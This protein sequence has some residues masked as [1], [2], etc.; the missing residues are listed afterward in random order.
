[1]V[2]RIRALDWAKT[3]LGP[4]DGWPHSLKAIVDTLLPLGLPMV[5]MWG[6]ELVQVYNDAACKLMGAK[7][8]AGLGQPTCECWPEAWPISAPIYD[9]VLAG[10]TVLLEDALYR[11][12]RREPV[13]DAWFTLSFSPVHDDDGVIA[14]V[15]LTGVE[16]TEQRRKEDALR[17]AESR[18]RALFE[19]IDEGYALCE[20]SFGDHGEACDVR[21]LEVNAGF[22]RVSG[23][24]NA[25]GRTARELSPN[26]EPRWLAVTGRVVKTGEPVRFEAY[27]P[28][29]GRWLDFHFSRV[30]GP[31][32]RS[33]A[34]VFQDTTARK[35]VEEALRESEA[36]HAYLLKLSDTLR[37]LEDPT[38]IQAEAARV[39][40]EHLGASRVHYGEADDDPDSGERCMVIARGYTSGLTPLA[41]RFRLADFGAARVELM[42]TAKN[43]VPDVANDPLLTAEER[44]RYLAAGTAAWA[45]VPLIKHGR[46]VAALAVHQMEPRSWTDE[47]LALLQD[48][49]DRTWAAVARARAEKRVD[50]QREHILAAATAARTQA[51]EANRSKDEF[52]ATLSHELRTPLAPILLW[53]RA[54][55]SGT[56][57][58]KDTGRAVDAI[59]QSAE[60]QS[61]LIEDLLDL[62]RLQAGKLRLTPGSASVEGVA[63]AA[64]E[65]VRPAAEA[66]GVA[67]ALDVDP[68]VGAA[69]LDAGRFQQVLWNLLSNAV[70]FT[71]AGGRTSLRVRKVAGQLEAEVAD[72]GQGIAPELLPHLFQRFRQ[73]D[74][75]E[76][77]QHAGLGIGL[78]LCRHLVELH[79]GTV[80]AH[81]EGPGRGA[82][83][84][85]R[86]PFVDARQGALA[87]QE[88]GLAGDSAP[89]SL[90]GLSVL[91]VE[92]DPHTCEVISW[93][94]QRA[95]AEVRAATSGAEALA[96]LEADAAAGETT[97]APD[98]IVCDIGLPG[99]SGHELIERIAERRDARGERGIPACA[100]SA[101]ARE[102]DRRRA[103]EA[104]FELYLAKPLTAEA[105]LGAVEELAAISR[106][107]A[108]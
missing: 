103:I 40:G 23:L 84:T 98:V 106:L 64:M 6:P 25:V 92:D 65:V 14:G 37:P 73:L 100:V 36:R 77:R 79:G 59:V 82:S 9:R 38:E 68:G 34:V 4:I 35:K 85:V 11:T 33:L 42:L 87:P 45:S 49:A 32:S 1:M 15:L 53:G 101:H 91:L 78:A 76:S 96:L 17:A 21:I 95:G 58:E 60:S 7:H 108:R 69:V 28:T 70:K 81:S 97:G 39:L 51:E 12:A 99:M 10:E 46:F 75:G 80:E 26:I 54:L 74:A 48:T 20:V 83:F 88:G 13:E 31:D 5:V 107:S 3:P 72:T 66:K 44:A 63:R 94:L 57:P 62:S 71:P 93:I 43:V 22:A 24:S 29:L 89:R 27:A 52:L 50:E 67:L 104:G 2:G 102:V 41:G 61:R 16:T 56:V 18:Y 90:R 47:E 30:G 105:L 8:P 55:R 19:S 86:I